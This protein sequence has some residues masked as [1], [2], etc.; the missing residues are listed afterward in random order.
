[1][2]APLPA[3]SVGQRSVAEVPRSISRL[4]RNHNAMSDDVNPQFADFDGLPIRYAWVHLFFD[5]IVVEEAKFV[6]Y[7]EL[8]RPVI[9]R[10]LPDGESSL[11]GCARCALPG[12]DA[13]S[14]RHRVPSSMLC[15]TSKSPS[16][17][18]HGA[19]P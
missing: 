1:M 6:L 7:H 5:T 9:R 12:R 11:H 19:L 10:V 8:R 4:R 18:S 17:K 14:R 3:A 15:A 2:F 16:V 13:S